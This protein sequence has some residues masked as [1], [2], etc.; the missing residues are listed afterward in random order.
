MLLRKTLR[1]MRDD[2][3]QYFAIFILVAIAVSMYLCMSGDSVGGRQA[4]ERF[5]KKTDFADCWIYGER[6][7]QEELEAIRELD[8][9]EN[10]DLRMKLDGSAPDYNDVEMHIYIQEENHINRP[11]TADGEDFDPKDKDGIWLSNKFAEAHKIKV[12]DELTVAYEGMKITKKV[13]G[14]IMTPE[15]IYMIA[16]TDSDTNFA[17][18]GYV[19]LSAEAVREV[20]EN[21]TGKSFEGS[22]PYTQIMVRAKEGISIMDRQKEMGKA[23]D[24]DYAVMADSSMI[25]GH[26]RYVS[27]LKQHETFSYTFAVLFIAIVV[28]IISSTMKRMVEKQRTEIGTMNACGLPL[29]KIILHYLSYSLIVAL[30]GMIAG[31]IAG[32]YMAKA[33]VAMFTE[34]YVIPDETVGISPIFALVL[35]IVLAS[36]MLSSYLSC[37]KILHIKPAEALRPAPPKSVKSTGLEKLPFWDRLGFTLQYILRGMARAKFRVCMAL[38]GTAFSMMLIVFSFGCNSLVDQTVDWMF[39]KIQN[40]KYQM[41]VSDGADPEKIDDLCRNLKG[42]V[43]QQSKIELSGVKKHAENQDKSTHTLTVTEG[44]GLYHITDKNTDVTEISAGTVALTYRLAKKL[45]VSV[46]DTI[47]WHL[48]TENEWYES[49]VGVINRS[50]ETSG[51]TM[52]RK[53]YEDLG[54]EFTPSLLVTDHKPKIDKEKDDITAVYNMSELKETFIEGYQVVQILVWAMMLFSL[55]LTVATLYS[56]ANVSFHE[57]LREYA[58]LKVLGFSTGSIRKLIHVENII[59][60]LIGALLGSPLAL[61]ALIWMMNSNGENFDY[62]LSI[63]GYAYLFSGLF[64]LFVSVFVGFLFSRRIR[65]LDMVEALKGAE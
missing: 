38:V 56:S 23:L 42:E 43:V 41:V 64:I 14:L 28:M 15:Y 6:F 55:V 4:L 39:G 27:E 53:D 47:Y 24:D 46:G 10:A 48:Y 13:K 1:E 25:I 5:E 22:I 26:E 52:L 49:K 45:G 11:L 19:Y 20:I 57:R 60:T 37:R 3:G 30:L 40:F 51:I 44:K 9:V 18:I 8:F 58:T 29:H 16:K 63:P 31:S 35:F 36:C 54:C 21:F 17:N 65:R 62:Y 50:P 32:Y 61:P 59:L 2:I 7:D 12:G 34:Y 33:V